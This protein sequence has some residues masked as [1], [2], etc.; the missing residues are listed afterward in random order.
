ML[1]KFKRIIA[2][3]LLSFLLASAS[4][5]AITFPALRIEVPASSSYEDLLKMSSMALTPSLDDS[6]LAKASSQ[7]DSIVKDSEASMKSLDLSKGIEADLLLQALHLNLKQY[8][9]DAYTYE[10]LR[11]GYF[12]CVTSAMLYSLLCARHGI[13]IQA[14][15]TKD[16]CFVKADGVEVQTTVNHGYDPGR[17]KEVFDELGILIGTSYV[18]ANSDKYLVTDINGLI[19]LCATN[20][21]GALTESGRYQQALQAS[22]I[23]FAIKDF[24]F[25]RSALLATYSNTISYMQNIDIPGSSDLIKKAARRYS[26]VAGFMD[27]LVLLQQ[28]YA[29]ELLSRNNYSK[30][31]SEISYLND[32]SERTLGLLASAYSKL[33][34]D[35]SQKYGYESAIEVL[36]STRHM[37]KDSQLSGIGSYVYENAMR[38]YANSGL[39]DKILALKDNGFVSSESFKFLVSTAYSNQLIS[40]SSSK[41]YT[42]AYIEYQKIS[43]D[44]MSDSLKRIGEGLR[45]NTSIEI[46]NRFVALYQEGKLEEGRSVLMQGLELLGQDERLL[47]D[48]ESVKKL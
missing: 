21:A 40:I 8:K 37:M 6:Q 47:K 11:D 12:N 46:H 30:A 18:D 24:E 41:S 22:S 14:C 9:K 34:Q 44:F 10:N 42:V 32:E 20:L 16:H 43:P 25:T 48:L 27:L 1:N 4:Y 19:S 29:I 35:V 45:N 39:V 13:S 36:E 23:A 26:D 7:I 38:Q 33:I 15:Y 2:C 31:F 3:F 28:N 5:S 17:S